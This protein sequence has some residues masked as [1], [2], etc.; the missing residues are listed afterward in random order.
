MICYD[1]ILIM[2]RSCDRL[3]NI[4]CNFKQSA[5]SFKRT[6]KCYGDKNKF[7]SLR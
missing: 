5:E 2:L 1:T 6:L 7:F 4:V 3:L